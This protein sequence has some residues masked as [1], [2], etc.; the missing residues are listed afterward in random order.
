MTTGTILKD[1]MLDYKADSQTAGI[2]QQ[3]EQA[4][5]EKA[6]AILKGRLRKPL[7]EPLCSPQPV[8]D[9]LHLKMIMKC[10]PPCIWTVRTASWPI[11]NCTKVRWIR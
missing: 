6:L 1:W 9:F 5:I 2:D 11:R 10:F 8:L 3:E 7:T 4:I